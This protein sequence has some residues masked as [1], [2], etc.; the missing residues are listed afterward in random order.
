MKMP[1]GSSLQ[2]FLALGLCLVCG[3][4][5]QAMQ[6]MNVHIE[7][8]GKLILQGS[9]SAPDGANS[10]RI[11]ERLPGVELEGVEAFA[12]ANANKQRVTLTGK[13][14]LSIIRPMET[15][16][17][18]TISSLRLVRAPGAANKWQLPG[19]EVERT[20][21]AAGLHLGGSRR[22]RPRTGA[23]P[24]S[25]QW[26]FIAGLVGGF[27]LVGVIFF[28]MGQRRPKTAMD[29]NK[30]EPSLI[31]GSL[32]HSDLYWSAR[33]LCGSALALFGIG[34]L[35]WSG[36]RTTRIAVG[37]QVSDWV[38]AASLGLTGAG[39]LAVLVSVVLTI[40]GLF[41]KRPLRPWLFIGGVDLCMPVLFGLLYWL[42]LILSGV[43]D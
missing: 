33:L 17:R 34:F 23:F 2:F 10:A 21:Q 22:V 32:L 19:D 29:E 3:R 6:T 40:I 9:I 11:W 39:A 42:I 8:N 24:P 27:V 31:G 37:G 16:A 28:V 7:R 41:L 30:M 38:L 1:C 43:I 12:A 35:L 15:V 25:A 13:I 20:A 14:R 36:L 26:G 4:T 18:A 5:A